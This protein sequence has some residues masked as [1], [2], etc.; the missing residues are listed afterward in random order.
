[1][2]HVLSIAF[3]DYILIQKG[4]LNKVMIQYKNQLVVYDKQDEYLQVVQSIGT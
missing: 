3:Y 4:H 1:M 2:K